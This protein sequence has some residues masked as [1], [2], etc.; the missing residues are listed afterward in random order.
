MILLDS[1]I[2]I[3]ATQ[4]EPEY[5]RLRKYLL[6]TPHCVSLISYVEV[7]GFH[8]IKEIDKAKLE[9]FF[10]ATAVLSVS[11]EIAARAVGL[12]QKRKMSLG[13][14]LIGATA[15]EKGLELATNNTKDFSWISDLQIINPLKID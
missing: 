9:I 13:D 6:A 14:A 11:A 5:D 1:N 8:R 3:F 2:V 4:A 10:E 12:R 15:L 7:L